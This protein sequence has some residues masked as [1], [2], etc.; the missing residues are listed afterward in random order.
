MSEVSRSGFEK[1]SKETASTQA[2]HTSI[3]SVQPELRLI[4]HM[5]NSDSKKYAK[6]LIG[7]DATNQESFSIICLKTFSFFFFYFFLFVNLHLI[8]CNVHRLPYLKNNLSIQYMNKN[9]IEWL[10]M[11]NRQKCKNLYFSFKQK[12]FTHKLLIVYVPKQSKPL[13]LLGIAGNRT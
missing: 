6:L 11:Q 8:Y 7:P 13:K 2:N 1:A 10:H 12:Y 9:A 3:P 5:F 4:R